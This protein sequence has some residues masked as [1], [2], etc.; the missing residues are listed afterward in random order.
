MKRQIYVQDGKIIDTVGTVYNVGNQN[1]PLIIPNGGRWG[2]DCIGTTM[3][4]LGKAPPQLFSIIKYS[5]S[6][7]ASSPARP[8]SI[9]FWYYLESMIGGAY[10]MNGN[11][12]DPGGGGTTFTIDCDDRYNNIKIASYINTDKIIPMK[13]NKWYYVL[14]IDDLTNYSLY[15]NGICVKSLVSYSR[16][17]FSNRIYLYTGSIFNIARYSEITI[18]DGVVDHNIIPTAPEINNERKLYICSKGVF[19]ME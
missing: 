10:I 17:F 9:S 1:L 8:I 7:Y 2:E 12:L 5:Y 18:K 4:W 13:L 15:V 16:L 3:D 14:F 11:N 6:G 19:R